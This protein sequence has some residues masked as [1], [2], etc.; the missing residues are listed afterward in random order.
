MNNQQNKIKI[1]PS[2]EDFEKISKDRDELNKVKQQLIAADLEAAKYDNAY[3]DIY[4][5]LEI[6]KMN[7]EKTKK[8]ISLLQNEI[9]KYKHLLEENNL[10]IQNWNQWYEQHNPIWIAEKIELQ[11]KTKT[12]DTII[13]TINNLYD[14]YTKSDGHIYHCDCDTC[15]FHRNM[16]TI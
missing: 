14:N 9:L 6:T 15:D 4:N 13:Q 3:R 2:M 16:K 11:K 8:E 5:E 1:T 12:L 7:L 10:Q